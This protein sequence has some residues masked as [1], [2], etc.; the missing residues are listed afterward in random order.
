MNNYQLAKTTLFLDSFKKIVLSFQ[1]ASIT[2]VPFKGFDCSF[3]IY[4]DLFARPLADLDFI[5][6]PKDFQRAREILIRMGLTPTDETSNHFW[7]HPI[8]VELQ[9]DIVNLKRFERW[10]PP[11]LQIQG[12]W[13]RRQTIQLDGVALSVLS[14]EDLFLALSLHFVFHHHLKGLKWEMDLKLLMER[15]SLNWELLTARA[16]E[17]GLTPIL[18]MVLKRLK[19]TSPLPLLTYFDTALTRYLFRLG[20]LPSWKLKWRMI[21]ET[22]IFSKLIETFAVHRKKLSLEHHL[23]KWKEKLLGIETW[24]AVPW[25]NLGIDPSLGHQYLP[26]SYKVL[27]RIFESLSITSKDVLVDFGSGKGRVLLVAAQYPFK[28]IIGVDISERLNERA[29]KNIQKLK[30]R[31]RCKNFDWITEEASSYEVPSDVSH[32]YLFHPF[33][34]DCFLKVVENIKKSIQA[35]PRPFTLIYFNP[36]YHRELEGLQ[37]F[38]KT[39]EITAAGSDPCYIYQ[40]E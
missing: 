20:M 40:Y 9:K 26:S 10:E 31:F 30:R 37:C 22:N 29:K 36:V 13:E 19:N 23:T 6:A 25:S 24:R 14:L 27:K 38:K 34:H 35:V 21:R 33:Y 15:K 2:F 5:V 7:A 18:D 28:K 8:G 39:K 32:A 4:G 1:E 16:N 12:F 11:P 3:R 17:N